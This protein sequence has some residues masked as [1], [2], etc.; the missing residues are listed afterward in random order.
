[1]TQRDK[2]SRSS[3]FVF[4]GFISVKTLSERARC[5]GADEYGLLKVQAYLNDSFPFLFPSG[6]SSDSEFDQTETF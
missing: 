2:G 3:N 1:M 4:G 6:I 5:Q